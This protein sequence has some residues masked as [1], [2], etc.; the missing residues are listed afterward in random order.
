MA[1]QK[2]A[3]RDIHCFPNRIY[4]YLFLKQDKIPGGRGY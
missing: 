4:L 2:P 3:D 1:S